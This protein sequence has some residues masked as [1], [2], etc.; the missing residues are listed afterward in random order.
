MAVPD[1][2]SLMLPLLKLATRVSWVGPRYLPGFSRLSF[3][4]SVFS[5]L[6]ALF[7]PVKLRR[8]SFTGLA[9]RIRSVCF[10]HFPMRGFDAK[11]TFDPLNKSQTP[12]GERFRPAII[13]RSTA[14]FHR[15]L[16]P[17]A[18]CS[19]KISQICKAAQP[20]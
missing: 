5:E 17:L 20:V 9:Q 3:H 10:Q 18:V 1:F 6:R 19:L 4:G 16:D 15:L 12:D 13:A 7:S 8:V 2:Q 11:I 14:V